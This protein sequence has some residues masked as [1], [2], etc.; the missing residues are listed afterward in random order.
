M[1]KIWNRQWKSIMIT[2]PLLL[3]MII[4]SFVMTRWIN[5][6]VEEECF[7]RLQEETRTLSQNIEQYFVSDQ[8]R[9]TVMASVA[10]EY[11]DMNSKEL[12]EILDSYETRGMISDLELLLPGDILMSGKDRQ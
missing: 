12:W 8:E 11:T 10:A 1:K 4:A 9:L 6:R 3:L 2:L 5:T 7:H